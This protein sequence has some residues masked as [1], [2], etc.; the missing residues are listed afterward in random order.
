MAKKLYWYKNLT[1]GINQAVDSYLTDNNQT[2]FLKNIVLDKIGNWM[3]RKGTSLIASRINETDEVWGLSQYDYFSAS[4]GTTARKLA[5]VTDR[6]LYFSDT[7]LTT[8]GSAVDTDEFPAGYRVRMINFLNRLYLATDDCAKGLVYS[9]GGAC[10]TITPAIPGG[11]VALTKHI[12]GLAGNKYLKNVIFYTEP[13]TDQFHSGTSFTASSS[14]TS[15]TLISSAG[16]FTAD[17]VGAIAF[18][19]TDGAMATITKWTSSTQV[20]LDTTINNDWDGDTFYVLQNN[21]KQQKA[22]TGFVAYQENFVSFDED[23]MYVWDPINLWEQKFEGRGCVNHDTVKVVGGYLF[24]VG[25]N[26]IF[27]WDGQSAPQDI[28]VLLID[29][30]SNY[31]LWD[32]VNPANYI[33]MCAGVDNTLSKYYLSV[34]TLS[35]LSGAPA[36]AQGNAVFVFDTMKEEWENL[37]YNVQ[38]YVFAT[39]AAAN[40]TEKLYMGEKAQA[41]AYVLNTGTTD[42]DGDTTTTAISYEA[43]TK[44]HMLGSP[45][46]VHRVWSYFVQYKS[47]NDVTMTVNSDNGTY[48]ACATLPSSSTLKTVEVEPPK[49]IEGIL[50][51]IKFVGTGHFI[52]KGYGFMAED[53]QTTRIKHY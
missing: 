11:M 22:V 33:H 31:G 9:T 5:I 48:V 15:T 42:D 44:D 29:R 8:W 38:P 36:S 52:L 35:T 7:G 40:A 53:T 27:R 47:T 16:S 46:V 23:T 26:G 45:N 18:N 2:P 13:Y 34:G 28:S 4:D 37:S 51:S 39:F 19:T 30:E 1:G 50:H 14:S 12:L 24:W 32:L 10:T 25:R 3:T 21:F 20:T 43:R 17:M 6:D 49:N 41:A